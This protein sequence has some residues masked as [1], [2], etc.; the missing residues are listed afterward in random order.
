LTLVL[1]VS[2]KGLI[3]RFNK[4]SSITTVTGEEITLLLIVL[5]FNE[6]S[7]IA[8]VTGKNQHPCVEQ[9]FELKA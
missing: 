5:R 6:A 4:T 2:G 8:M 9:S 1:I 3:Q 7:L